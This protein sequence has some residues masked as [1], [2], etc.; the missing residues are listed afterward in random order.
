MFQH[1]QAQFRVSCTHCRD[2]ESLEK[3]RELSPSLLERDGATVTA[4]TSADRLLSMLELPHRKPGVV[5][6]VRVE[7]P[8]F[9]AVYDALLEEAT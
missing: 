4:E 5:R 8:G 6:G 3:L 9:D 1:L 7:E 2:T